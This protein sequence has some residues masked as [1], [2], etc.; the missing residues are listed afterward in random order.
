MM[1]L[2]HDEIACCAVCTLKEAARKLG[3]H[4]KKASSTETPTPS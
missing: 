3:P 4:S 1:P 2:K